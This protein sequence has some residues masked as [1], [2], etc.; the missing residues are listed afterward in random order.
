LNFVMIPITFS[1]NS[2]PVTNTFIPDSAAGISGTLK[3][4]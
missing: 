4:E 3:L 2:R 1:Y